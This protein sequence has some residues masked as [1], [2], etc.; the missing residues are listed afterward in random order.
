MS[1]VLPLTYPDLVCD[2][3]LD[4]FANETTSDLQNLIQDVYHLL[5]ELSGSNLDDPTR[6]IGVEQYLNGRFDDLQTLMNTIELQISQDDRVKNCQATVQQL[7]NPEHYEIIVKIGVGDDTIGLSFDWAS[8]SG[9]TNT[10]PP[11]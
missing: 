7:A 9:L 11:F 10:T 2:L 6:G 3:D 4:P 5:L 8:V 1:T